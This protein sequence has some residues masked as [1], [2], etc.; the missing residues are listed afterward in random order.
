MHS[1]VAAC[2]EGAVGAM[3]ASVAGE[4]TPERLREFAAAYDRHDVDAIMS[5]FKDSYWKIVE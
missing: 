2:D 5:F 3:I 1:T 4:M